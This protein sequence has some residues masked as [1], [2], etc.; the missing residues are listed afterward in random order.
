MRF[1]TRRCVKMPLRPPGLARGPYSTPPD[2]LAGFGPMNR[3]GGMKMAREGWGWKR[4][5]GI[6][7]KRKEG[8]KLGG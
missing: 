3:E 4:R 2:H 8:W 6:G 5:K 1:E 7:G